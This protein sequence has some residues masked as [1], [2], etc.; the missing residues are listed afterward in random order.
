MNASESQSARPIPKCRW[1]HSR[2]RVTGAT[3]LLIP[4]AS[5]L[6]ALIGIV[7]PFGLL[8][9]NVAD[10]LEPILPKSAIMRTHI[11]PI[12]SLLGVLIV[13]VIPGISLFLLAWIGPPA[14]A[15]IR[16]PW[17]RLL[18]SIWFQKGLRVAR[19]TVVFGT[20]VGIVL[21]TG[22]GISDYHYG[23][24]MFPLLHIVLGTCGA[25]FGLILGFVIGIVRE[26]NRRRHPPDPRDAS[27]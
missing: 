18:S 2:L 21:A 3:L 12:L 9:M 8:W 25:T 4:V 6:L 15:R 22:L 5:L 16:T 7:W 20:G 27:A 24:R 17:T 11:G 26:A 14:V 13:Y 23:M 19:V 1:Y 10:T